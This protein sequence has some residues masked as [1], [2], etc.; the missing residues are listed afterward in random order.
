MRK[1][2]A[3]LEGLALLVLMGC[4][5]GGSTV[6]HT[7]TPAELPSTSVAAP[8]TPPKTSSQPATTPPETPKTTASPAVP[9]IAPG[10]LTPYGVAFRVERQGKVVLDAQG[11]PTPVYAVHSPRCETPDP[12]YDPPNGRFARIGDGAMF[13]SPSSNTVYVTGHSNRYDPTSPSWPASR[14]QT[15]LPGDV[16]TVTTTNGVYTYVVTVLRHVPFAEFPTGEVN[17]IV[18]GRLIAVACEIAP[19]RSRYVGNIVVIATQVSA[20]PKV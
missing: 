19:D 2:L 14:L 20:T 17:A 1:L 6:V 4:S 5:A 13:T 18:P 3:S 7:T 15:L 10:E 8:T 16:I 12:C 11:S 9:N